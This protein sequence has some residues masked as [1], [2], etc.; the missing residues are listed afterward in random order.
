MPPVGAGKRYTATC[1]GCMRAS[2]RLCII[3]LASVAP[4][5]FPIFSLGKGGTLNI[6]FAAVAST[7]VDGKGEEDVVSASAEDASIAG[8]EEEHPVGESA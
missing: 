7:A 5:F 8:N 4:S 3:L 1:I 6:L 2:R